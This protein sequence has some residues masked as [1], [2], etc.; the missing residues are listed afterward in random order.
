MSN[1]EHALDRAL[2]QLLA[3][4]KAGAT[5]LATALLERD[6][7]HLHAAWLLSSLLAEDRAMVAVDAARRLVDAFTRRGDLPMA[8]AAAEAAERAG[9]DVGVL[10]TSLAEAFGKGS[11]RIADVAPAPPPLPGA[12]P[13]LASLEKLTGAA[14]FDHAEQALEAFLL[15]EDA[16]PEEG[17]VPELPLFGAL[18][19][20]PLST[21]LDAFALRHYAKG[22]E[23]FAAG[24]RGTH[25]YVVARGQLEVF[26]GDE[27]DET[28]L[29][30]LGPGA[31]FGEMALVSDAP[32]AAGV[33]AKESAT[34][35]EVSS[36]ELEKVAKV[37]PA[38]GTELAGF[39]RSR[40]VSNLM[41]H[42]AL[43]R[44]VAP[45]DRGAMMQHFKTRYFDPGQVLVHEESESA[46]LFLVASG[47]VEVLKKDSDG[48]QIRIAEL[49]PGDVV[50]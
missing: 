25:A 13:A 14:L 40:M 15:A 31:I 9:A 47:T 16:M 8:L 10:H 4:D 32:R 11:P 48:D 36:E 30:V 7:S 29:A 45:G 33:R 19:A 34:L 42:G 23:V 39:C 21:L 2:A 49:G 17:P 18:E 27:D 38:V 50:G 28:L 26:R 43:L 6:P 35:L 5:R 46:G 22:A 12:A 20:G 44:S 41:R 3:D 1:D 24:E 37:A